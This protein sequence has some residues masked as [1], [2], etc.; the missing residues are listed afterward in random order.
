[1]HLTGVHLNA[2]FGGRWCFILILVLSGNLTQTVPR[3]L[4]IGVYARL[5][6]RVTDPLRY[7]LSQKNLKNPIYTIWRNRSR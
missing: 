7:F 3:T 4:R 2:A 6:G 1:V 5:G